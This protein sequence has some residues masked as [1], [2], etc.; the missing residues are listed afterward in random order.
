M[1][2]DDKKTPLGATAPEPSSFLLEAL[3]ITREQFLLLAGK[4]TPPDKGDRI[5]LGGSYY[6]EKFALEIKHVLDLMDADGKDRMYEYDR[7][8]KFKPV[9]LRLKLTQSFA[10]LCNY[11]DTP[12][13]KYRKLRDKIEIIPERVGVRLALVR[14]KLES[15][16]TVIDSPSTTIRGSILPFTDCKNKI[17]DFIENSRENQI[18]HIKNIMLSNEE[19]EVLKNSFAQTVSFV[20]KIT[21]NEIK[22]VH[23]NPARLKDI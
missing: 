5:H 17:D 14:N 11:L 2:N 6:K 13:R 23:I 12:D 10:Y 4:S 18:L 20:P 7:F 8:P 1:N 21:N 16:A 3:G 15:I 19:V 22:V 9:S